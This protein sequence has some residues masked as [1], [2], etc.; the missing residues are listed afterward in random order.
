MLYFHVSSWRLWLR[1][2]NRRRDIGRLLMS[3][4]AP[5]Y[6]NQVNR[7]SLGLQRDLFKLLPIFSSCYIKVLQTE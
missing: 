4:A 2:L 7:L 5:D 3:N 6:F 1:Y